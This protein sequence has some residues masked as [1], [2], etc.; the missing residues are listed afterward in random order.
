ML[1]LS[2]RGWTYNENKLQRN[3]DNY[4]TDLQHDINILIPEQFFDQAERYQA[5]LDQFPA[6]NIRRNADIGIKERDIQV[7]TTIEVS[8]LL[9][10]RD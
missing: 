5:I 1:S 3:L 8:V 2:G 7:A 4:R 9:M 10:L 6:L